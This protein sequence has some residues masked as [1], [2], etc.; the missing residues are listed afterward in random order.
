MAEPEG[1]LAAMLEFE[2]GSATLWLYNLKEV[3]YLGCA[4]IH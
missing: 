4:S 3:T 2:P 1:K